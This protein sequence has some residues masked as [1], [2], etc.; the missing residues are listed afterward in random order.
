[1]QVPKPI[2]TSTFE[3]HF[4]S[5]QSWRL[6]EASGESLPVNDT[7]IFFSSRY[8]IPSMADFFSDRTPRVQNHVNVVNVVQTRP[9]PLLA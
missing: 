7:L 4:S 2:E 8:S 1:M 9:K 5:Q 3:C 6:L